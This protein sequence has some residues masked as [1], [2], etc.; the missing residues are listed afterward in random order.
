MHAL[1]LSSGPSGF[2]KDQSLQRQEHLYP[3]RS[4]DTI[5]L[6]E[7][8]DSRTY[9]LSRMESKHP[10]TLHQ[11]TQLLAQLANSY[12][13]LE[14]R[15][16]RADSY[17]TVYLDDRSFTMYMQ[18]HNGKANRYKLR[19][20]HYESSGDTFLEVKKKTNRGTTEKVRLRTEPAPNGFSPA[21]IAF[22]RDVFPLDPAGFYPVLATR[23]ERF[24][25]VSK[26]SPE[27]ITFDYAISFS[28]AETTVS[29]PNL[30]I[31]EVKYERGTKVS[32]ALR[33][34]HS[35]GI[36]RRSFSK[37]CIGVALL[38]PG[39]KHNRFKETLL[40]LSRISRRNT[41]AC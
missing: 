14:I 11:C 41:V 27:R 20:R 19:F 4:L 37:Y 29:F 15:G 31:V 1:P 40:F 5:S 2:S 13:I 7:V 17:R 18:H 9:L 32:R 30:V 36:A 26:D 21:E 39:V 33:A 22:L 35:M 12:C 3:A 6:G 23:Y 8:K 28:T 38:Y 25:L 10:M 16:S 34:L 24:T